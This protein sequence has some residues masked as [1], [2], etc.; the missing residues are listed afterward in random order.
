MYPIFGEV[1]GIWPGEDIKLL[2]ADG[3]GTATSRFLTELGVG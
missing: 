2:M 3:D 1:N